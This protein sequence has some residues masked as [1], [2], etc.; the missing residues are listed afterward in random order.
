MLHAEKCSIEENII[1]YQ[2]KHLEREH[3]TYLNTLIQVWG[4]NFYLSC[5]TDNMKFLYSR[6]EIVSFNV[7]ARIYRFFKT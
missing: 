7:K 6:R 4:D 3:L 2:F 5:N 1:C